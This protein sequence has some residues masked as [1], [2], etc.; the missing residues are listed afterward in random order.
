MKIKVLHK[1]PKGFIIGRGQARIGDKV[2]YKRKLYGVV[3][4]IFGPVAK[5]YIKIKPLKNFIPDVVFIDK[6]KYKNKK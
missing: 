5:P 6:S 4:D 1:T 2:Y 3:V